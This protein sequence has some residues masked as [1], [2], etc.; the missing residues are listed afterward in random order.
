MK[1]SDFNEGKLHGTPDFPI[2]YYYVNNIHPQYE[3]LPHWHNEFEIIKVLSG[4]F[5]VFLN[6]VEYR[7]C[8]GD[9]LLI[10]GG[11]LHK[12]SPKNCM[13][14]CIVFDLNMLRRKKNDRISCI[15][16]P[17]INHELSINCSLVEKDGQIY[18]TATSLF[19]ELHAKKDFYELDVYSII[20]R[21]FSLLYKEKKLIPKNNNHPQNKQ[22]KS[23]INLIDW[24]DDNFT[25]PITLSKLSEISGLSEKYICRIFKEYTSKSPINYIN[26]L[27]ID[28]ACH[29]IATSC[30]NITQ[31]AYNSGFNDLSYFSKTFKRFKGISPHEY[32]KMHL[33]K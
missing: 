14:E 24:I 27:R 5:H 4:E 8:T 15:L 2:E 32:K 17:I 13:Y 29:E 12:G 16:L 20:L 25:E 3:M 7:L 23:V 30:S 11:T 21:L 6:S 1:Y 19:L 28:S 18:A 26:E 33:N 22:T 31:A 9:I 10:E